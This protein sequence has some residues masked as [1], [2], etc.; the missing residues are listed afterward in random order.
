MQLF[1][2]IIEPR[3]NQEGKQHQAY[4]DTHA[5]SLKTDRLPLRGTRSHNPQPINIHIILYDIN[6]D[7][8]D[9]IV[10][11]IIT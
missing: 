4:L 8:L 2:L 1:M 9:K 7:P 3:N 11:P 6:H 5:L 10:L